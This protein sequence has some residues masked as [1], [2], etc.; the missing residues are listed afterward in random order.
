MVFCVRACA[1]LPLRI[2]EVHHPIRQDEVWCL[3]IHHKGEFVT[4]IRYNEQDEPIFLSYDGFWVRLETG[5]DLR[6]SLV[7]FLDDLA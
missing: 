3:T 7:Q 4:D 5:D 1:D 6:S 2:Q